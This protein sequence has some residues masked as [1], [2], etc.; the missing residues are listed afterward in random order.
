MVKTTGRSWV[1]YMEQKRLAACPVCQIPP[2]LR[3]QFRLLRR[4]NL[5]VAD[6]LE[7]LRV[8]WG[9]QITAEAYSVHAKAGHKQ[10]VAKAAL[11]KGRKRT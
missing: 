2:A 6:L 4:R 3:A 5:R 7:W 1:R 9:V 11:E 10:T 8:E